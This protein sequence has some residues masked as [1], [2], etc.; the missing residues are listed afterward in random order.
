VE[1]VGVVGVVEIVEAVVT[2]M[3]VHQQIWPL[4]DQVMYL[5]HYTIGLLAFGMAYFFTS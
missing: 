4:V 2:A 3:L 5:Q 1:I